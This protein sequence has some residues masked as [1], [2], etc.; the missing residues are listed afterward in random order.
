[1]SR[2]ETMSKKITQKLIE[3]IEDALEALGLDET[4]RISTLLDGLAD[5]ADEEENND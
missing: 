2:R 3:A 5:Q 4:Q 1:M